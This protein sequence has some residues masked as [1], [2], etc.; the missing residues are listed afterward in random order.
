ML[1]SGG[2][3]QSLYQV[4]KKDLISLY[5]GIN[6]K[7]CLL[8]RTNNKNIVSLCRGINVIPCLLYRANKKNAVSLHCGR[9]HSCILTALAFFELIF[10]TVLSLLQ[11]CCRLSTCAQRMEEH[12]WLKH[13]G[14]IAKS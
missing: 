1:L 13:I 5:R 9:S 11:E 2:V 14:N 4:N 12:H 10:F 3:Y 8:Y 7:P 6:V